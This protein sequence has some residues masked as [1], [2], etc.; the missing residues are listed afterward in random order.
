MMERFWNKVDKTDYCWNW[1][2]ASRGNGY[3]AFKV[4]EKVIDS[5]RFSYKLTNGEI[6][7]GLFVCHKCDNKKCVNPDH[8]F[9]GTHSDNMVD[10]FKKGLIKIPD[11]GKFK[12]GNIP[13]NKTIESK[14]Q[15]TMMF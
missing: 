15:L 14:H 2:G 5:H 9:L 8:L 7:N 11:G 10:A 13:H 6:P 3:G 4:D 1:T 12:I